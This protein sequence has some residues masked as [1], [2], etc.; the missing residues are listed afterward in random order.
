MHST[1]DGFSQSA[2][3][4]LTTRLPVDLD[5]AAWYERL[6]EL[7]RPEQVEPRGFAI[8]AYRGEK[9]TPLVGAFLGAIRANGGQPGL[10]LKTGTSD[11][12]ILAP[13][14]QC[15][16]L[17]YGPGDSKLDHTPHEHISLAE[18]GK[19]VAALSAV[20]KRLC[21]AEIASAAMNAASQ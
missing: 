6:R 1:E 4:E 19:A 3:L 18:Y 10:A 7:A 11:L 9:N 21:A 5:P 20:L 8:P 2:T 14:W 13:Q 16:A 15:P 12:N 17:V